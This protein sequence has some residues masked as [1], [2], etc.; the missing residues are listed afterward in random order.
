MLMRATGV[1]RPIDPLGRVVIPREIL[2]SNEWVMGEDKVEFFTESDTVIIRKY[3]PG[4]EFCKGMHE[5]K[6]F[7]GKQ[8]CGCCREDIRKLL[9][10]GSVDSAKD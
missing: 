4:C 10:E 7:G 3:N 5:L 1:T 9:K 2:N 6:P 8:I